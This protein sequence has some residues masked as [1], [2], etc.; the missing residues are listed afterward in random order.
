MKIVEGKDQSF[1]T[2]RASVICAALRECNGNP[3]IFFTLV[4]RKFR[5]SNI[6][7][8]KPHRNLPDDS[9]A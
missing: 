2:K 6:D 8:R 9:A 4:D 3:E 7:P 1:G 5:E